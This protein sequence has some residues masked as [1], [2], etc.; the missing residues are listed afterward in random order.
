MFA[1]FFDKYLYTFRAEMR[2][3]AKS[4]EYRSRER[5]KVSWKMQRVEINAMIAG[6]LWKF[7]GPAKTTATYFF[8]REG[9]TGSNQS[10]HRL[11]V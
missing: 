8:F 7:L 9:K 5:L 11:Q 3:D 2:L 1:Y 4:Q 6:D 10:R